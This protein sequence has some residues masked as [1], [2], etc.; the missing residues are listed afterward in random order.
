[1]ELS[2]SRIAEIG[3]EAALD[4]KANDV[5]LLD[6]RGLS[7]VA[8]FFIICSGNSDTHV[9][10]IS[11]IIEEK[12]NENDT[13]LW[14][15]EGGKRASWVLLDYID[16]IV[17]IFTEEARE[18]YGLERLWGDAPKTEYADEADQPVVC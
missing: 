18:F 15:R 5:V 7:S 17:H 14:H 13:K 3:V 16:V 4:R 2:G 11:N 1:M 9:E 10:G 8:D 12:L 6:L